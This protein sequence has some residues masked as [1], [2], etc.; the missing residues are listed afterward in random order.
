MEGQGRLTFPDGIEWAGGM[1]AN[2]ID[3]TG[4]R[5]ALSMTA[6]AA[7]WQPPACRADVKGSGR[8]LLTD[9]W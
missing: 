7:W 4:V 2:A 6:A 8:G 3:G 5:R 9:I 1:R